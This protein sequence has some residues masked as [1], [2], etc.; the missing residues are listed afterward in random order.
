MCGS[1]NW[2]KRKMRKTA[3]RSREA[4]VDGSPRDRLCKAVVRWTNGRNSYGAGY[5]DLQSSTVQSSVT[6]GRHAASEERFQCAE[7]YWGH[8]RVERWWIMPPIRIKYYVD[9]VLLK[10]IIL[11][12][13]HLHQNWMLF[14]NIL[15]TN[16]ELQTCASGCLLRNVGWSGI[17]WSGTVWRGIGWSGIGW[18]GIWWSGI[19]WSGIWW[20][21]IGW[22]GIGWSGIGRRRNRRWILIIKNNE[23]H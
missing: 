18:S 20:S 22:S 17:G 16:S 9:I 23:M 3:W 19:W 1:R 15:N 11:Y 14:L 10:V 8:W 6:G 4:T 7:S 13:W 2:T 5:W 21:G 12:F